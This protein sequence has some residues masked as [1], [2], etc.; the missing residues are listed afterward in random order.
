MTRDPVFR[1]RL[2]HLA[3]LFGRDHHAEAL[4]ERM[5]LGLGAKR[6]LPA[7]LQVVEHLRLA[8]KKTPTVRIVGYGFVFEIH[9]V[10]V[11]TYV[12]NGVIYGTHSPQLRETCE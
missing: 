4:V 11:W 9:H 3:K 8:G 1:G 7:K 5:H 2:W 12:I 10:H 6:V